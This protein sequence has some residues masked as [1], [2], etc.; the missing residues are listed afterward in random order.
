MNSNFTY[1]II[2]VGAG[3]AGCEAALAAARLGARTLLLT[4]SIDFIALPPCNPSIGGTA[5]GQ[6]V[7]EIDALGGE[8]G[9]NTDETFIQ[10][11]MLNSSKGPAV[12][13]LRAQM[14][15]TTYMARMRKTLQDQ[16]N[17]D[18]KQ[19]MVTELVVE[20]TSGTKVVKGVR[21]KLGQTF[22]ASG[23]IL[24]TGTSLDSRI[25]IGPEAYSGGRN[26]EMPA[27]GLS[28]DL[29]KHG[30]KLVRWK[31]GTPPRLNASSINWD[32]AQIQP[33]SDVPLS[34]GHYYDEASH[35]RHKTNYFRRFP[36]EFINDSV[37]GRFLR[38]HHP[39]E[40]QK[41]LP[42]VPCFLVNTNEQTHDIV[43]RNLDRA[44]MFNGVI[45]GVGPRYCPS[46]EAKVAYFPDKSKHQFFLEPEGWETNEVYLQGA[47]TSLPEEV[48]WEFVQSIHGLENAEITRVGYAIEYDGVSPS[49]LLPTLENKILSNLFLAGQINGTSGYEEA[50]GQGLIAGINAVRKSR[51]E[52][53][54][55]MNR[56]NSY[57]GVMI[58]DLINKDITEP[59]RLMTSRSE[60]RLL[61]RNDNADLRLSELGHAIGLL[62]DAQYDGFTRYKAELA[63]LQTLLQHDKITMSSAMNA[64]LVAMDRGLELINT[65]SW[66]DFLKR[67]QANMAVIKQLEP[68]LLAPYS[69]LALAEAEIQV[70]YDGYISRQED[71]VAKFNKM[72]D[73][74]I[75]VDFDYDRVQGLRNEARDRLKQIRPLSIGQASRLSG[76]NPA[77]VAL[78]MVWLQR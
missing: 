56:S 9:K 45:K 29:R 73:R 60:Y 28:D 5:K 25:I 41:W 24:T 66:A 55:V 78:L 75:P 48:Q 67:P 65:I 64:R 50:A 27:I 76:V 18:L 14:D 38:E 63:E 37:W 49:Q 7:R 54:I 23:V 21:T 33:G 8:M 51:G 32:I 74:K 68:T 12:Q 22:L 46:F 4:L 70:K 15:R 39:E 62:P 19:G 58:D 36:W 20:E 31:T 2:V 52:E 47:N 10:I 53:A 57:I 72:E 16:P 30:I 11:R 1:D 61:L 43:R 34:F 69:E 6:V 26:G 40:L 44:P 35:A 42:Q 17:L 3:H 77:D 59:Y 71:Q 13:S